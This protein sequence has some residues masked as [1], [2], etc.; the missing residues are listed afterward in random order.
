MLAGVKKLFT[1]PVIVSSVIVTLVLAGIQKLGLLESFELTVFDQMV[2]KRADLPP[3]PRLLIVGFTEQDIQQLKQSSP[4]G[5]VLS[6]VLSKLES[7]QARVIALDF[8]RDVPVEPGHAKLLNYLQTSDKILAICSATAPPPQGLQPNKIGFADLPE[9]PDSVI[10]RALLFANPESKSPCKSQ[11]SIAVLAALRYLKETANI[12]PQLTRT[13][14]ALTLGKTV[15]PRLQRNSGGYIEAD[16]GGF[17]ILLNYRSLKNVARQVSFIDVLNNKVNPDWVKGK[18]ILIGATAPSKQDIRNTP[19]STGRK[20]NLG[21]M[22]GI[23]IHAQIISEILSAVLDGRPIFWYLPEWGE[24]IWIWAW[25][26]LGA[27]VA[28]QVQHPLRLVLAGGASLAILLGSSFFIFT[29]SG[30]VPLAPPALGIIAAGGS[31]VVYSA[32]RNKQQGDEIASKIQEQEKTISLLQSLLR[33]GGATTFEDNHL[34]NTMPQSG[35]LLNNRYRVTRV[36]GAGGFSYTYLAE[37][38]KRPGFPKCVVKHLQP[39]QSDPRFLEVARRLFKTEAEILEILGQHHQIPQLFAYFEEKQ[40]FYL[41]QE[42]IQGICLQEELSVGNC[43][44]E[45]EVIKLLKEVLEVLI[46]VHAHNVIHRDL[47]PSNLIRRE[48]DSKIVLID[49]GAV[50]QI[51][52]QPEEENLTVAVGTLGYASPEQL[53]GQPRL[54]SDIHALGMIGIQALTGKS[55]K[56]IQRDPQTTVPIWQNMA[57]TSDGLA[58]ILERMTAYDYLRRYQSAQEVLDDLKKL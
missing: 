6:K 48:A 32:Y 42:F 25:T 7:N 14:D 24:I 55:A 15:F 58:K 2:Q 19:Y 20:D 1:Q 46:F 54:N 40:Q 17:Q 30:W 31:V 11:Y 37:D 22:P 43:L 53:M 35:E 12:K 28:S 49:F 4:S 34:L 9:D 39:A 57:K 36:L 56:E 3:D 29:L 27:S 44:E 50:K 23:V 8:F 51:Q 10:R 5:E 41:V 33:E 45:A 52:P 13:G 38:T 47:K 18:I 16:N 21:K 26:L